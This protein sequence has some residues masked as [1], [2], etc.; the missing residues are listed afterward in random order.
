MSSS[1]ESESDNESILDELTYGEDDETFEYGG[2]GFSFEPEHSEEV[3][4]ALLSQYTL[5]KPE[6]DVDIATDNEIPIKLDEWYSCENCIEMENYFEC[7]C[8]RGNAKQIIGKRFGVERCISRTEAFR[9]VCLNINVLEAAIGAWRTFTDDPME[10]NNRSYRF[11]A[12]R[13]YISW[14]FGWLG[15]DVRKVIPS[16]VV[17]KIRTTFPAEDCVYIPFQDA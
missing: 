8:C 13:Q 9:D 3:V 11:I 7:E 5:D 12:Y 10:I 17:Q 4:Q 2:N 1:S 14:I 6:D 16:C 15:K